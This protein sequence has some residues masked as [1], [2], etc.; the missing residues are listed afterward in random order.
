M[1]TVSTS[2]LLVV[3]LYSRQRQ[4]HIGFLG[5]WLPLPSPL[6]I[7]FGGP[8]ALLRSSRS[9]RLDAIECRCLA[10]GPGSGTHGDA[11]S[12]NR[13]LPL[14]QLIEKTQ[15][16]GDRAARELLAA[17]TLAF[18]DSLEVECHG[19]SPRNWRSKRCQA[20]CMPCRR[21]MS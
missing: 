2:D 16:F 1:P 3:S 13:D 12:P 11:P 15:L 20:E 19:E 7:Q 10:E 17:S 8:F 18:E 21:T 9:L 5:K 6:R 14:P 4:Y